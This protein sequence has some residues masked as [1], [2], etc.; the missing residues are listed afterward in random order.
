VDDGDTLTLHWRESG[1]PP[2]SAPPDRQG[3]GRRLL[4]NTV[5]RQLGGELILDWAPD[6]LCCT[7]TAPEATRPPAP[8][9]SAA[10]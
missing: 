1:G 6:G 7:V 10:D 8:V 4:E 5:R 2:V 3:F 9:A